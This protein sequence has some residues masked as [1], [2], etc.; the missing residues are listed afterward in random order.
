MFVVQHFA[1][2]AQDFV[3]HWV[4]MIVV[5]FC[6]LTDEPELMYTVD[7]N[8]AKVGDERVFSCEG[9]ANPEASVYIYRDGEPVAQTTGA[10]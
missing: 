5:M 6:V 2:L 1:F 3:G 9:E 8:Q 7:E 10:I 4:C